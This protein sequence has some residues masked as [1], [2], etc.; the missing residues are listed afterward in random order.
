MLLLAG[1]SGERHAVERAPLV[2]SSTATTSERRIA[3]VSGVA[4]PQRP[5]IVLPAA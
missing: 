5:M 2:A 1:T 3:F 4:E